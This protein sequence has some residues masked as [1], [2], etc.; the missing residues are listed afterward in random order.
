MKKYI[1][2]GT[3]KGT[4]TKCVYT[5]TYTHDICLILRKTRK[6]NT[7]HLSS[8]QMGC[9]CDKFPIILEACGFGGQSDALLD[10]E[11]QN[12]GFPSPEYSHPNIPALTHKNIP[13]ITC[14]LEAPVSRLRITPMTI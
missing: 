11:K 8:Y 7:F 14:C 10:V 12:V 3:S 1:Y 4:H 13:G 5:Y 6:Q 2:I 9:M